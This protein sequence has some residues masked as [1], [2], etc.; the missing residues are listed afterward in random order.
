MQTQKPF[1]RQSGRPAGPGTDRVGIAVL[2][3]GGRVS[4]STLCDRRAALHCWADLPFLTVWGQR[5]LPQ[6]WFGAQ[7][8]REVTLGPR[9]TPPHPAPRPVKAGPGSG[10][11]LGPCALRRHSTCWPS[12][13]PSGRWSSLMMMTRALGP[14]WPPEA[15]PPAVTWGQ[16][17]TS[18][19]E[20]LGP[21]AHVSVTRGYMEL[22]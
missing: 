11:G 4:G 2:G 7:P 10:P 14:S 8:W 16:G 9:T 18:P 6:P 12:W 13:L 1:H 3:P 19:D 20:L 21:L 5:D 15:A 17:L 22:L